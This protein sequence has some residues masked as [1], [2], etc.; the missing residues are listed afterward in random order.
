M[1]TGYVEFIN[2]DVDGAIL[3]GINLEEMKDM[4]TDQ[5]FKI[6]LQTIDPDLPNVTVILF[7]EVTDELLVKRIHLEIPSSRNIKIEKEDL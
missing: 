4:V 3:L 1:L 5:T 2:Q 7:S 6:N